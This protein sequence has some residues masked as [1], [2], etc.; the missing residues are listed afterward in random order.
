M[1]KNPTEDD[2][3]NGMDNNHRRK[4]KQNKYTYADEIFRAS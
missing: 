2:T 1:G 4:G 3:N